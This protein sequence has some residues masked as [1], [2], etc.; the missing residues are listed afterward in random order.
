M[1]ER[2]DLAEVVPVAVG[3]EVRKLQ[4][5]TKSEV[6]VYVLDVTFFGEYGWT[7]GAQHSRGSP[8]SPGAKGARVRRLRR[9]SGRAGGRDRH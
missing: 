5:G 4:P 3:D 6:Y 8:C 7:L 9:L 1:N 2:V